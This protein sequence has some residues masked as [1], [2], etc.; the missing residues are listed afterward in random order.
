MIGKALRL[1]R[2]VQRVRGMLYKMYFK[3]IILNSR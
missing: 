2:H 3:I 1:L